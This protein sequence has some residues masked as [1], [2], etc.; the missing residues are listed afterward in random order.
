MT[1]RK[2]RRKFK[3]F[4]LF[5]KKGISRNLLLALGVVFCLHFLFFEFIYIFADDGGFSTKYWYDFPVIS[6]ISAFI[7]GFL[8]GIIY[9][10]ILFINRFWKNDAFTS[11]LI[12]AILTEVIFTA[13]LLGSIWLYFFL[14][15]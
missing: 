1:K 7:S 6:F 3:P 12:K 9:F 14:Q 8:T 15:N 5:K 11:Y 2:R 10:G 13:L 4:R